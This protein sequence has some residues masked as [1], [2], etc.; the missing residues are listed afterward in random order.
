M[1]LT[2]DGGG[3]DD[4]DVMMMTTTPFMLLSSLYSYSESSH[5]LCDEYRTV[6]L[7]AD[8]WTKPTYMAM[9][10]PVGC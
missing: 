8:L 10:L 7:A 6:T 5:G 4:D 3:D 2:D 1:I 9:S